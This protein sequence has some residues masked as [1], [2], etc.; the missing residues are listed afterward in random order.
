MVNLGQ[1]GRK[2]VFIRVMDL[3]VVRTSGV[4]CS[5]RYVSADTVDRA[6]VDAISSCSV[7][8]ITA[9]SWQSQVML[10]SMT[11]KSRER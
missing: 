4:P 7:D 3:A 8:A 5:S 6:L 11:L 9:R 2:V 1:Q 10:L